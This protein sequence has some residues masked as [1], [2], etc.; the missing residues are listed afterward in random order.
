MRILSTNQTYNKTYHL[1]PIHVEFTSFILKIGYI[2]INKHSNNNPSSHSEQGNNYGCQEICTRVLCSDW[3]ILGITILPAFQS[4][5]SD[6]LSKSKFLICDL[7]AQDYD[8]LTYNIVELKLTH[9]E[10]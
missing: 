8:L 6:T 10:R 9:F 2:S 7:V 4:I 3:K 1:H 5:H